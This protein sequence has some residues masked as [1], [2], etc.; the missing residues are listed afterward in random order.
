MHRLL[1]GPL[2][3]ERVTIPIVGLSPDHQ[4][5]RLVQLSDFHWD[6][7]RLSPWLL[8]RAIAQS[9]AMTPDL[10]ML[11]GDFVTKEPTPIHEL[12]RHLAT[13][14]SRYGV[15]AVLGN[16][17]NFSLKERLTIIEG[18]QQ[19]GIQVLWNQIAYPLGPGL[20]VVGLAD[21]WSREF[22]PALAIRVLGP[23]MPAS[24]AVS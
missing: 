11:T 18:L 14:E 3:L 22:A 24:G 9:N 19:A 7:L 2:T 21:L 1:T 20:A 5:L 10:V 16:H 15:Y 17:D 23:P 12:A 8:R 13:L 4:G 6:G